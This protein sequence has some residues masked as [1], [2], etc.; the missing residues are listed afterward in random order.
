MNVRPMV[1]FPR[2]SV[3][4]NNK[5]SYVEALV[6]QGLESANTM[7]RRLEATTPQA[8]NA[9]GCEVFGKATSHYQEDSA[10]SSKMGNR[11]NIELKR[12]SCFINN[13]SKGG[14]SSQ[15]RVKGRGFFGFV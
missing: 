9:N 12:L 3:E 11:G 13:D 4:A 10:S 1:L 15:G 8:Q 14:S 2:A 6:G 5:W 7:S